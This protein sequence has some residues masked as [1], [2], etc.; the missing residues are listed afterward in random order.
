MKNITKCLLRDQRLFQEQLIYLLVNL[1]LVF[2]PGVVQS[3]SPGFQFIPSISIT[4]PR[5]V[6]EAWCQK[7][8][9]SVPASPEGSW[10]KVK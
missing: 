10:T 3:S 6:N 8:M 7:S 9:L 4:A 2:L 5:I 1:A